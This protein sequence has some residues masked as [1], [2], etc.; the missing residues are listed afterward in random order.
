MIN[1]QN[2]NPNLLTYLWRNSFNPI[3]ETLKGQAMPYADDNQI[4]E[5]L[6]EKLVTITAKGKKSY[7]RANNA[8]NFYHLVRDVGLE[9]VKKRYSSSTFYDNLKNLTDAGLQK[10]WLQNLHTENKQGQVIPL[11]RFCHVDFANQAPADYVPPV[12]N[13]TNLLEIA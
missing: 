10:A 1:Y 5:M 4:Y 11:V 8:M 9:E 3:F 12:S 2:E 13:F 6:K 7:T